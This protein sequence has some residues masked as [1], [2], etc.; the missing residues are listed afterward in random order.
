MATAIETALAKKEHLILEAGTGVGK[1]LAYLVPCMLQSQRKLPVIVSTGTIALQEQLV[2]KDLPLLAKLIDMPQGKA[3]KICL[4]KGRQHY[5]CEHRFNRYAELSDIAANERDMETL[6]R[7]RGLIGRN[8]ITRSQLPGPLS[9]EAW[10]SIQSESGLCGQKKCKERPCSFIQAR[11]EM[12]SADVIVVNHSLL[13]V[14][15]QLAKFG[16]SILPNFNQLIIDE[17]HHAPDTATEQF[18]IH[19]SNTQLKYFLD[20]LYHE[21]RHRG[22]LARIK[23]SPTLLQK[24]IVEMRSISSG[25]FGMLKFWLENEAPDNGRLKKPYPFQN[26]LLPA[27]KEMEELLGNWAGSSDNMDEESEFRYYSSR[28]RAY[29]DELDSFTQQKLKNAAYWVESRPTRRD[30]HHVEARAAPLNVAAALKSLLFDEVDSVIL[31]SA[32]LSTHKK[33]SFDYFKRRI[34]LDNSPE[35]AV[36]SPFSYEKNAF[37]WATRKITAPQDPQ[38]VF[39]I[40]SIISRQ[41]AI[42]KGGAFILTTSHQLLRHLFESLAQDAKEKGYLLIAQGLSGQRHE[43]LEQFRSHPKA[44]LIGSGTFWEGIDVPGPGLRHVIIPRLPFEVPHHP[45]QEARYE[46]IEKNGGVP[47]R[48]LALPQALIKFKQGFGRLIRRCE[49]LGLVSVLDSRLLSKT[50]GRDFIHTLPPCQL[51][52]DESPPPEFLSR[53]HQLIDPSSPGQLSTETG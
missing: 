1:S 39:D 36:E 31:T 30:D 28:F 25:F 26:S 10:S 37:L 14:H 6:Q 43:L 34:G 49:D 46:N 44:V 40:P 17:A 19:L 21:K 50:Y 18:G 22:F 53:L 42:T 41:L 7:I 13:F 8:I 35:K 45:L 9:D 16:A 5:L 52:V 20:Q 3:M 11:Q 38:W 12:N 29:A 15:L 27:L 32:T 47:F 2:Q 48:D 23:P 33:G 4:A 24:K 51:I